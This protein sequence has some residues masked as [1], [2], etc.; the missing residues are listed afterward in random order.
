MARR[1]KPD[2]KNSKTITLADFYTEI[3]K[4]EPGPGGISRKFNP[5]PEIG[6]AIKAARLRGMSYDMIADRVTRYTGK[7][8]G[9]AIIRKYCLDHNI[10]FDMWKNGK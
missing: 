9:R 7:K 6:E 2:S 4:F 1:K 10:E 5:P 8:V 3:K